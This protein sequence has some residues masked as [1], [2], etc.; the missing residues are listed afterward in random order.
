MKPLH[1]VA[2][3]TASSWLA[4]LLNGL[5]GVLVIPLLVRHLGKDGY[6]L[7]GLMAV[8]V[9]LAEVADLGLRGALGRHL[10]EH[11][12]ARNWTRFNETASTALACWLSIGT[13]MATACFLGAAPITQALHVPPPLVSATTQLVRWYASINIL[14]MFIYPVFGA[15][16]TS[17]HRFDVLNGINSGTG[18]LRGLAFWL[19]FVHV[20]GDLTSW[21]LIMLG[22]QVVR[23]LAAAAA[24]FQ[25]CPDLTLSP[26][27]V[28]RDTLGPLFSLGGNMF[29]LQLTNML[30]V[31]A[32]PFILTRFLGPAAVALYSPALALAA[33]VR[34]IVGTLASQIYPLTTEMHVQGDARRLG[35]VLTRGTRLTVLLGILPCVLLG[36]FSQP[37]MRVWLG[38][39]LGPDYVLAARV[40]VA[41]TLV[42]LF[43]YASGT[44]WPVLLGMNRIR[45]LV[46]TQVPLAILNIAASAWL[47][48]RTDLGVLGVMV[49]TV[50]FA[51]LR[52]PVLIAYTARVCGLRARDYLI[53]GYARSLPVLA[54]TGTVAIL[55]ARAQPS[56]W[57][58]LA[59]CAAVVGLVWALSVWVVGFEDADRR[60]IRSLMGATHQRLIRRRRSGAGAAGHAR[61]PALVRAWSFLLNTLSACRAAWELRRTPG[62]CLTLYGSYG[63]ADHSPRRNLGDSAILQAMGEQIAPLGIPC[64][65]STIE[66]MAAGH[67]PWA[68]TFTIGADHQRSLQEWLPIVAQSRAL[69]LGGGG[70]WQDYSGRGG[71]AIRLAR[72]SLLFHL[73][74]RPIFWYAIGVGPLASRLSRW[75]TRW[76]AAM[77]DVITTRDEDSAILL[78]ALGTPASKVHATA[79]PVFAL[80]PPAD[81]PATPAPAARPM[82]IGLSILPFHSVTSRNSRRD[83][84]LL[85]LYR[86]FIRRIRARGFHVIMLAFDNGQDGPFIQRLIAGFPQDGIEVAGIDASIPDMLRTYRTLDAL[87]GMRFHSIVLGAVCGVPTGVVI[88]HPKVRAL[89]KAFALQSRAGELATLSADALDAIL[90]A[91]LE[92]P[93]Q[94]RAALASSVADQRARLRTTIRLL[95]ELLDNDREG[96]HRRHPLPS[97]T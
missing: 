16:L 26:S 58:A 82:R 71:T 22:T 27:L 48:A 13:L 75:L 67:L 39:S 40:L 65:V 60:D 31:K 81:T 35:I 77:A 68:R 50:V 44:Q 34:P 37:I 14:L 9:G 41:W 69:I 88:Y 80:H 33:L 49:P 95:H 61:A 29:V 28:R 45:F 52:R 10:A 92:D 59:L 54:V 53:Q 18:I 11:V 25:Q 20:R 96:G 72:V 38:N 93:R 15:C 12:A 7:A 76:G 90:T 23:I 47:V 36:V 32:D 17:S 97:P 87:I 85:D 79:D 46:A 83:D 3:N 57:L 66:P 64:L 56:S 78:R 5:I 89:V 84:E 2:I 51:I 91:V 6:G 1:Q 74:G 4:T 19:V 86:T 43:Q 62:T 30:S 73:A 70:L 94:A 42:D 63:A 55:L 8:I 24:S 21:A